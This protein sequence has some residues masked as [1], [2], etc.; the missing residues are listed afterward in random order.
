MYAHGSHTSKFGP[1][2][3]QTLQLHQ[4]SALMPPNA[5]TAMLDGISRLRLTKSPSRVV[6]PPSTAHGYARTLPDPWSL[7]RHASAPG[8]ELGINFVPAT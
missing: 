5:K 6:P 2:T 4:L 1:K 8:A 7:E 3:L